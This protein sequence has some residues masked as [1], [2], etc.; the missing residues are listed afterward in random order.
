MSLIAFSVFSHLAEH[1]SLRWVREF[2]RILNPKGIMIVTTRGRDFIEMCRALRGRAHHE[3]G[4]RQALASSFVDTDAAYK[5]YDAGQYL[6]S[7]TGGGA[8]RPSHFLRRDPDS[9]GIRSGSL[10]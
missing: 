9:R 10:D 7:P 1:A 3:F 8:Y 2:S 5:A 4:W 6:H